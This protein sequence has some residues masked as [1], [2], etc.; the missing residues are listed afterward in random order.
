[1]WAYAHSKLANGLSVSE[2]ARRL[3]ITEQPVVSSSVHPEFVPGSRFGRFLPGPLSGLFRM[4][5]IVPG[6]SSVADGAAELLHV[7][8]SLETADVSGRYFSGQAHTT[9]S[10]AA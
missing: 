3:E 4:L 6:T 7:A 2:L 1:M 10:E 5:G 9:P 8:V